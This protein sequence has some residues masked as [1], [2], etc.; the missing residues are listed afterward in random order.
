MKNNKVIYLVLLILFFLLCWHFAVIFFHLNKTLYPTPSRVFSSFFESK[1]LFLDLQTS[2][3][4]LL[5]GSV[6]G[7]V[8]GILF[9]IIT[10]HFSHINEIFGTFTNFFRFIPPLALVPLFLLWFGIGEGSKIGLLAWT[11][12]F[13]V[14]ISTYNGVKNLENK[15][16]YVAKSLEIRG[17]YFLREVLFKGSLNYILNGTRIGIGIAFSVLIAAEMIGAYAGLGYRIFFL[18]SVYRVDMMIA[19]IV[20]LGSLGIIIDRL[21]VL[22]SKKLTPW[23]NDE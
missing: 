4:R 6:V 20:V 3:L 16:Y 7:I 11:C 8:S 19:Y 17:F 13:P 2:L 23:K 14:W 1:N 10:G 12:F 15:Y 18:Q 21:F 9:G 5:L 22:L